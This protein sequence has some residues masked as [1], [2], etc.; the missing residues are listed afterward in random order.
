MRGEEDSEPRITREEVV[1]T[2]GKLRTD[3]AV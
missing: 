2:M 1:R 3:K